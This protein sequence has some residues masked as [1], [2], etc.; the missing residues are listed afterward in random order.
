M[1]NRPYLTP[2]LWEWRDGQGNATPGIALNYGSK[3]RAHMTPD[4]ARAFADQLHDLA[5]HI[6]ESRT[7]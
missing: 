7:P 1:S 3:L 5:D 6:E 2:K 4:E